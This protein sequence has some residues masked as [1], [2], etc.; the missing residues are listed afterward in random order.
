MNDSIL[1]KYP[2]QGNDG[3]NNGGF[4]EQFPQE[5][6]AGFLGHDNGTITNAVR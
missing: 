2:E 6:A 3:G 5:A 1:L 4:G